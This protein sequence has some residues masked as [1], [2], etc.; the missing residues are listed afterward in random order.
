LR[1]ESI[2]PAPT[3]TLVDI[4]LTGLIHNRART[5]CGLDQG[6]IRLEDDDGYYLHVVRVDMNEEWE[7][8]ADEKKLYSC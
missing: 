2:F 1:C 6:R 5:L 7:S 4:L 8:S 3:L